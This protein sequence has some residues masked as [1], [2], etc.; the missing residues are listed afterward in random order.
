MEQVQQQPDR[1]PGGRGAL[2][3][4]VFVL[5]ALLAT[6]AIIAGAIRGGL[7]SS[8]PSQGALPSLSDR[9]SPAPTPL[10]RPGP[11]PPR[12]DQARL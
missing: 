5:I 7:S 4:A 11:A 6:A 10:P 3:W 9:P 1:R 2:G 12:T 8:Q